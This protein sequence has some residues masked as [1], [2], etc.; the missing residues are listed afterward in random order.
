MFPVGVIR[1]REIYFFLVQNIFRGTFHQE[2]DTDNKHP[3]TFLF[4]NKFFCL[5]SISGSIS[6]TESLVGK[7]R[8]VLKLAGEK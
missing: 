6:H 4:Q 8:N 2:E 5:F 7:G 3:N 1:M